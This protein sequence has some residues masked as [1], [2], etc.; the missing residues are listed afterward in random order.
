MD[1]ASRRQRPRVLGLL[2]C[3]TLALA[4]AVAS[5]QQWDVGYTTDI[6]NAYGVAAVIQPAT[7]LSLIVTAQAAR[8][9]RA[10][11]SLDNGRGLW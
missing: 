9:G 10:R 7:I 11:K 8:A 1:V 3:V 5:A 6:S 2:V 4:P